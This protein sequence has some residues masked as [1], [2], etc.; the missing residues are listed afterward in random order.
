MKPG[1]LH[2]ED[3]KLSLLGLLH[4]KLGLLGLKLGLL[5]LKLGLLGLLHPEH[6]LEDLTLEDPWESWRVT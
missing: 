6:P 4:L 2:L 5:Y 3:S 1:L